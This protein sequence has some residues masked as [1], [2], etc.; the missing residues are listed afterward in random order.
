I[1]GPA[2]DRRKRRRYQLRR[3]PGLR[4]SEAMA[5]AIPPFLAEFLESGIATQGSHCGWSLRSAGVMHS[6]YGIS[7]RRCSLGIAR[8]LSPTKTSTYAKF[9]SALGPCTA[10]FKPTEST[11]ATMTT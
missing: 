2:D 9:S 7:K 11:A 1:V 4:L 6:S 8:F 3:Y 10:S 5:L